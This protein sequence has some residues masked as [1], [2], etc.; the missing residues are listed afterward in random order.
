MEV[1]YVS[2]VQSLHPR[3][4]TP[5]AAARRRCHQVQPESRCHTARLAISAQ[6]G[7]L[8]SSQLASHPASPASPQSSFPAFF[9][10]SFLLSFYASSPR[11]AHIAPKSQGCRV[12]GRC[13][14]RLPRCWLLCP[15]CDM[16][17]EWS[18]AASRALGVG[19]C[20]STRWRSGQVG[21][22]SSACSTCGGVIVIL[23][24]CCGRSPPSPAQG[25]S[26]N[27]M[28]R[29]AHPLPPGSVVFR[30][31][32]VSGFIRRRRVDTHHI[33]RHSSAARP[34]KVVIDNR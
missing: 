1:A 31:P 22:S 19:C 2:T 30:V 27:G 28:E 25:N 34:S 16:W 23:R 3:R 10:L 18:R 14:C 29:N 5:Q 15:F 13:R 33:G 17:S 4:N 12:E 24:R 21:G 26:R 8:Q 6:L 11:P 20:T 7:A 9:S 32:F